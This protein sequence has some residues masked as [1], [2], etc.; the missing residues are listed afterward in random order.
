[1]AAKGKKKLDI[2]GHTNITL[3]SSGLNQWILWF[4]V[5][6]VEETGCSQLQKHPGGTSQIVYMCTMVCALRI[7]DL[8][9]L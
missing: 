4:V 3:R 9:C 6:Y 1:M 8:L 5:R 2:A 7:I